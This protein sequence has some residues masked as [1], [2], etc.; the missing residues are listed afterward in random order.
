M[1]TG[2]PLVSIRCLVYNHEPFLRQCL[3]GFVMQKT[4]F[5]F[6]AIVHD[7]ASTD[8]SAAIIREYAEKYPDIIK[9]I[10]ETENQYHK[11]DGSIPRIIDAAVHPGSKYIAFCEGDDY[12]IDTNKLQIQVDFLETH[13]DY[14][15]CS[16]D[17]I[18]YYEDNQAFAELSIWG[19]TLS[20]GRKCEE[21]IDYSLD[22]FFERYWTRP[23]S[24]VY[25]RG[26]YRDELT[27]KGYSVIKDYNFYYYV[28]KHGKGAFFKR[29]MGV[30]R[31]Q[32][33]GVW[34]SLTAVQKRRTH[35]NDAFEIFKIEG[36]KNALRAART[37]TLQSLWV[38]KKEGCKNDVMPTLKEY[39][40]K[41]PFS[42][43]LHLVGSVVCSNIIECLRHQYKKVLR[44]IRNTK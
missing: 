19:S 42:S 17:C 34:S 15:I 25:R 1:M 38:M 12:W 5:P 9:P 40:Q 44:K 23:L 29:I 2:D 14:V 36:D 18:Y 6:E 13:P 10:F 43:F 3:D 27:G 26:P 31:V 7:D 4:N 16:H 20:E 21:I 28:L 35:A 33:N 39:Y 32:P 24:C 8:G 11:H 30:Y 41:A 22:T 37:R